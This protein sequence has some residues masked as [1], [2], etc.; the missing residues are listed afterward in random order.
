MA[1][2]VLLITFNRPN[3]TKEVLK[4]IKHYAPKKIYVSSDGPRISK[5]NEVLTV[6]NLRNSLNRLIDWDCEVNYLFHSSNLGCKKAVSSA[7]NWFFEKEE[8]GIIL[9]DD[10]VPSIDFF[11]FCEI[12]LNR[13]KDEEKVFHIDGTNFGKPSNNHLLHFSKYALIWGWATWRRA[14][15]YYD[16][17]M[18]DYPKFRKNN[19]LQ[20]IFSKDEIN[21]WIPK[22]DQAYQ[23]KIDTWDYQ[24]FYTIWKNQAITVRPDR[25][26]IKNIGFDSDATHTKKASKFLKNIKLEKL[27]FSMNTPSELVVNKKLDEEISFKRFNIGKSI[28]ERIVQKFF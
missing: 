11:K 28:F 6:N 10:C 24:W 26:L 1:V 21:Y 27:D 15:N 16:V 18:I 23:N 12:T 14:W 9:E 19:F 22:L 20:S 25:N 4:R 3:E 2:P 13:Y 17:D 7:I 8:M 5:T